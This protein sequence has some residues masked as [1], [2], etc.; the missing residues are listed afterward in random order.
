MVASLYAMLDS[1]HA[2]GK[3]YYGVRLALNA[4]FQRVAG[5]APSM[6]L[7]QGNSFELIATNH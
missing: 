4:H 6:R 1:D 5:V 7:I 3:W 2:F